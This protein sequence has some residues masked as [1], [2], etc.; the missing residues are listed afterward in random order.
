M[1]TWKK[2]RP[3]RKAPPPSGRDGEGGL[4]DL[5]L[6]RQANHISPVP[7]EEVERLGGLPSWKL[8]SCPCGPCSPLCP[9]SFKKQGSPPY[10]RE[11]RNHPSGLCS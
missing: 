5:A 8:F 7:G 3:I 9:W 6:K 2:G 1:E 11:P 10:R 4:G